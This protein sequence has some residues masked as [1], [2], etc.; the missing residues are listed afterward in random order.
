MF[1]STLIGLQDSKKLY[2]LSL[3]W[4]DREPWLI[5]L[6]F[7]DTQEPGAVYV[8]S[9]SEA[10]Q[11]YILTK[12]N[13]KNG[14]ILWQTHVVNG[15]YGTPAVYDDE[16]VALDS[17]D[18]VV[19]VDKN[20]GTIKHKM[21]FG[22]R[23][24]SSISI[25]AGLCW[26]TYGSHLI[27]MD[28]QS[29]IITDIHIPGAFLYGSITFYHDLVI[30]TGT[31]FSKKENEG[32]KMI[33][34][35]SI[36][37][38]EVQYCKSLGN[39]RVI[40][41]DSS[42]AWKESSKLLVGNGNELVCMDIESG[43]TIWKRKLAGRVDR[44][45]SVSDGQSVYYS[46]LRGEVGCLSLNDGHPVWH[47]QMIERIVC[48]P[49]LIG[50]SIIVCADASLYLADKNS[51]C[52]YQKISVGHCPY[53]AAV[54]SNGCVYLGGG[55]PP[56]HGA[57]YCF[58]IVDGIEHV[59]EIAD[60]FCVGSTLHSSNLQICI[61][62]NHS[63]DSVS[64]DASVISTAPFVTGRK[65]AEHTFVCD[66]PLKKRNVDGLYSLL[67]TLS[68]ADYSVSETLTIEI[69]RDST[70]PAEAMIS[71]FDT[72]TTEETPMYSGAALVQMVEKVYGRDVCQSDFRGIIDYLKENSHWEDADFQTWRLILKRALSS[73]ANNVQEFKDLEAIGNSVMEK[74]R[75]SISIPHLSKSRQ[76]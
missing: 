39:G 10:D 35:L 33:W 40:S 30:V 22:S 4:V 47:L 65:M 42:G 26:A 16:I 44:H 68:D 17:F 31:L 34:A 2:S 62:T 24:R 29:N 60:T 53:S 32:Q 37:T 46:T 41:S 75:E 70:L 45:C 7:L 5:R 23:M 52:I 19:F 66:V 12:Y 61:H 59:N 76:I 15:G 43:T 56:A 3:R 6:P 54:V 57:F 74:K 28:H 63:W 72:E 27:A 18:S 55:E 20:D 11:E 1:R 71:A 48:P 25:H 21:K 13:S 8:T 69:K 64:L 73:P 49:T 51:G 67:V 36:L 38:H 58:D 14:K 9:Y 50:G